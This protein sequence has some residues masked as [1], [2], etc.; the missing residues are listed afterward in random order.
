MEVTSGLTAV[1]FIEK[2]KVMLNQPIKGY[3]LNK[4]KLKATNQRCGCYASQRSKVISEW[5]CKS[6]GPME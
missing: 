6:I 1:E 2:N 4:M 3:N 5:P